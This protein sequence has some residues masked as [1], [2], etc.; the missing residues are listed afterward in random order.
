MSTL[1]QTE[2]ASRPKSRSRSIQLFPSDELADLATF[3]LT[4]E[5]IGVLMKLRLCCWHRGGLPNTE[6]SLSKTRKQ[7]LGISPRKWA[8]FWPILSVFF[9]EID[10]FL[11]FSADETRRKESEE[12]IAKLQEA[13][14]KGGKSSWG[15]KQHVPEMDTSH[16]MFSE[17]ATYPS[18]PFPSETE[19]NTK[20]GPAAATVQDQEVAAAGP[21]D[22]Q[23][24]ARAVTDSDFEALAMRSI[25]LGLPAP[26]RG[27]AAK[28]LKRFPNIA[29]HKFPL[30][31]G[32]RSSGL[33]LHKHQIDMELEIT[34]QE[35]K[36]PVS[37]DDPVLREW[38]RD[39]DRR[40][41]R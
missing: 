1:P 17:Q 4:N 23:N 36:K 40:A 21:P 20:G 24:L 25:N 6:E 34:R 29:P 33:W 13:G 39:I 27:M 9:T 30:F 28:I 14:R 31:H 3:S 7:L 19:A 32:Q 41:G 11:F 8:K 37:S 18:H 22:L 26:D 12:R 5:Q 10:G 38:A 35:T 15:R 2:P 16:P